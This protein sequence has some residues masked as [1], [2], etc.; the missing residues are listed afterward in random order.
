MLL[1]SLIPLV[2][3]LLELIPL[4]FKKTTGAFFFGTPHLSQH[5]VL[6]EVA[7][8]PSIPGSLVTT[9]GTIGGTYH[10]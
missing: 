2:I 3:L 5:A 6:A 7:A 1:P 9:S 4:A 10:I 8:S